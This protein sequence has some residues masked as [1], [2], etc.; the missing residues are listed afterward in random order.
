MCSG[1]RESYGLTS[2]SLVLAD[3]DHDVRHLM[4]AAGTPAGDIEGLM[5][6]ESLTGLEADDSF[7]PSVPPRRSRG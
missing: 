4:A 1:L 7:R 6:V 2:S 5:L 3:P